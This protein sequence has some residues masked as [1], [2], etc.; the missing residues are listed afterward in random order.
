[1]HGG[2]SLGLLLVL[3]WFLLGFLLVL[4]WFVGSRFSDWF[5]LVPRVP[6]WFPR[7]CFLVSGICGPGIFVPGT[8][9]PGACV[10]GTCV[11]GT[12]VPGTCGGSRL[13]PPLVS[14]W[15][16]PWFAPGSLLVPFSLVF[17]FGLSWFAVASL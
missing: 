15:F 17:I 16:P 5:S 12:C 1:M 8:C 2:L 13:V 10:P 7:G 6:S 9:G 11:P 3:S 14:S 4:S